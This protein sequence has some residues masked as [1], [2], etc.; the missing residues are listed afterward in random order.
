MPWYLKA[1]EARLGDITLKPFIPYRI[2]IISWSPWLIN[3]QQIIQFWDFHSEIPAIST[4]PQAILRQTAAVQLVGR[5]IADHDWGGRKRWFPDPIW[6]GWAFNHQT[7]PLWHEKWG[8]QHQTI[9]V[10][11]VSHQ[12]WWSLIEPTEGMEG[13]EVERWPT[14]DALRSTE[15]GVL[16]TQID[17]PQQAEIDQKLDQVYPTSNL[18]IWDP[19][20]NK[21]KHP[22]MA[23]QFRFVKY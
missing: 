6:G 22:Q 3:P 21:W 17:L 1:W 20:V 15:S 10:G 23:Q 19:M 9:E 4:L 5:P 2:L 14:L 8:F 11:R 7:W 12:N 13:V 18:S 16:S